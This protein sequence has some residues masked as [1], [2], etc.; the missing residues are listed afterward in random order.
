MT[1][2]LAQ[3]ALTAAAMGMLAPLQVPV[4]VKKGDVSGLPSQI[5]VYGM[6]LHA[7]YLQSIGAYGDMLTVLHTTLN[8]IDEEDCS[9]GTHIYLQVLCALGYHYTGQPEQ[10]K[11]WLDRAAEPGSSQRIHYT[12]CRKY[13]AFQWSDGPVSWSC[14]IKTI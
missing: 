6:Y 13:I 14:I 9:F 10:G 2:Q 5:R 11:K 12:L 8:L 4:W 1:S 7:K 3:V